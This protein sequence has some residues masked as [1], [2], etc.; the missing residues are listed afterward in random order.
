MPRRVD[1]SV[2]ETRE[3]KGRLRECVVKCLEGSVRVGDLLC[4]A[5]RS[6]PVGPLEVVELRYYRHLVDELEEN[7]SGL[8]L[9]SG[10]TV[11]DLKSGQTLTMCPEA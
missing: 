9:L 11:D 5:E 7:F 2:V 3:P 1:V 10:S 4:G 8:M 6:G